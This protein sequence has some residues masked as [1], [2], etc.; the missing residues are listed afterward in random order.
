MKQMKCKDILKTTLS[1][2]M[3]TGI[4]LN[5][6]GVPTAHAGVVFIN[7]FIGPKEMFFMDFKR[8]VLA[9][10][11]QEVAKLIHY[12]L[13]TSLQGKEVEMSNQRQ[14]LKHYDDIFTPSLIKA[15]RLQKKL[16]QSDTEP[17]L[18]AGDFAHFLTAGAFCKDSKCESQDIYYKVMA[19]HDFGYDNYNRE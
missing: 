19:I 15:I 5:S 18:F 1:A 9:G 17:I 3:L 8:K 14:F 12:P 7:E 11:K 13:L 4:M 2:M 10:D 16:K 6:Y